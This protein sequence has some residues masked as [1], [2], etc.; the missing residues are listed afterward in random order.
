MADS[1]FAAVHFSAA[2]NANFQTILAQLRSF[3][4]SVAQS[5]RGLEMRIQNIEENVG[6]NQNSLIATKGVITKLRTEFRET[7]KNFKQNVAN[8]IGSEEDES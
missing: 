4:K 5:F 3:E 8:G 7:V 1:D 6:N 2:E